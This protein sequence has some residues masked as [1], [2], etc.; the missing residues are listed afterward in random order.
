MS[1]GMG[2]ASSNSS[3]LKEYGRVLLPS[4]KRTGSFGMKK[5]LSTPL[6]LAYEAKHRSRNKAEKFGSS[7][8][9]GYASSPKKGA[10]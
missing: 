7:P 1:E 4:G 6:P 10:R 3:K 5:A 8:A 9:W 2:T